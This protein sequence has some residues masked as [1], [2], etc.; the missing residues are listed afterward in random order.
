MPLQIKN[1]REARGWSIALR[2]RKECSS[3]WVPLIQAIAAMFSILTKRRKTSHPNAKFL[4][5]R[6]RT[7]FYRKKLSS[8]RLP[9]TSYRQTSTRSWR[10]NVSNTSTRIQSWSNNWSKWVRNIKSRNRYSSKYSKSSLSMRVPSSKRCSSRRVA[11]LLNQSSERERR[12][13]S[14]RSTRRNF[15]QRLP[16]RL[17]WCQK[18]KAS[19]KQTF[20]RDL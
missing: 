20:H 10:R 13:A 5:C 17:H 3:V 16:L 11:K 9:R 19:R 1:S 14:N 6:N 12:K 8:K 7:K 18:L 2:G 4:F 15:S